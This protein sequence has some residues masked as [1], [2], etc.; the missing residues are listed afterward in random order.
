M[1]KQA[2]GVKIC[3]YSS[4]LSWGGGAMLGKMA[5]GYYLNQR[6]AALRPEKNGLGHFPWRD[7]W[8]VLCLDDRGGH[9]AEFMCWIER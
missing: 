6:L 3:R 7:S 1:G 5:S 4:W 9:Q 2:R 8:R